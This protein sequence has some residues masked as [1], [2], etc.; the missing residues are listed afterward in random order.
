MTDHIEFRQE[1]LI[2]ITPEMKCFLNQTR[3]GLKG[4]ERRQFML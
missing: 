2:Q 4:T 1:Q 3:E